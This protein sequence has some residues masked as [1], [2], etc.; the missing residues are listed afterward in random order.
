[1]C[2]DCFYPLSD[3]RSYERYE[4]A[5]KNVVSWACHCGYWYSQSNGGVGEVGSPLFRAAGNADTGLSDP[6]LLT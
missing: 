6:F 4:D 3:R 5:W 2:G 1:M